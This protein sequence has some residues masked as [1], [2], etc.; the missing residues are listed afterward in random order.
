MAQR[1]KLFVSA[2][3]LQ[4][5]RSQTEKLSW[6]PV[7]MKM[8]GLGIIIKIILISMI[9]D[10]T[11]RMIRPMVSFRARTIDKCKH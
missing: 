5:I 1:T 6:V 10:D 7:S 11:Y 3:R 4:E 9:F 2:R 8:F